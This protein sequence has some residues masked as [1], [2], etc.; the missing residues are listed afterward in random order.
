RIRP[1]FRGRPHPPTAV[2]QTTPSSARNGL[3]APTPFDQ[4]QFVVGAAGGEHRHL[5]RDARD[6][7][8]PEHASA[9]AA[10]D[11]E[12]TNVQHDVAELLD[13][14]GPPPSLDPRTRQRK[15]THSTVHSAKDPSTCPTTRGLL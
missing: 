10:R 5:V 8:P 3:A 12:I 1:V 15:P 4:E 9:E 11:F 13:L 2:L 7:P 14:H 6:L